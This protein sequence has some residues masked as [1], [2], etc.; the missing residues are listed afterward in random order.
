MI[1]RLTTTIAAQFFL[2]LVALTAYAQTAQN[3]ILVRNVRVADGQSG[4]LSLSNVLI[5]A[6]NISRVVEGASV[7][8]GA[9]VIDGGG[10]ILTVGADGQIILK[11]NSGTATDQSRVLAFG[12]AA[13]NLAPKPN[14]VEEDK[15]LPVETKT[16]RQAQQ[17]PAQSGQQST[18]QGEEDLASKVVDPTAALKIITFQT[19]YSPSLWGIRDEQNEGDIQLGIPFTAFGRPNILKVTIPYL[20]S[21]PSGSRGLTDVSVFDIALFP[22]KWGTLVLGAVASFGVNKGPGVDTFAIGPAVG[23]V[24]K[25]GRWTYGVFN[26]NLFSSDDIATTQIQ[27]ILGYTVNKKVSLALGDTQYTYDWKQ[28]RF[29]LVPLG[30]QVNYIARLGPQPIRFLINPQYNFKNEFG[31]RKW[32]ITAGLAF[33][34]K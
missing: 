32:T 5:L 25:K 31:S 27:P 14:K 19:K 21:S 17:A 3:A 8:A 18:K 16:P 4:R 28:D 7:P 20:T 30:I 26:Q 13:F 11:C 22:K 23:T 33:I 24:F 10:C 29:V 15:G 34:V 12:S 9:T 1:R 6:G 2:L